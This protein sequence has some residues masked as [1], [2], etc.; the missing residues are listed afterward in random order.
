MRYTRSELARLRWCLR[1]NM[2]TNH[3]PRI[4]A[5]WTAS[6]AASTARRVAVVVAAG[7]GRHLVR[8]GRGTSPSGSHF[9]QARKHLDLCRFEVECP[10]ALRAREPFSSNPTVARLLQRFVANRQSVLPVRMG[11]ARCLRRVAQCSSGPHES[12]RNSDKTGTLRAVQIPMPNQK[13]TNPDPTFARCRL[14]PT[15]DFPRSAD[16]VPSG[17]APWPQATEARLEVRALGEWGVAACRARV[18]RGASQEALPKTLVV[19]PRQT[20]RLWRDGAMNSMCN[21]FGVT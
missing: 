9:L 2:R 14:P 4:G 18:A 3:V 11:G 21:G 12:A 8:P 6:T 7:G 19:K 20:S 10:G 16:Q 13:P 15:R 17:G 1:C 5:A